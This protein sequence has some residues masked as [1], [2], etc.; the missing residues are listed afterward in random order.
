MQP[1]PGRFGEVQPGEDVRLGMC[2]TGQLEVQGKWFDST[3]LCP[4]LREVTPSRRPFGGSW[5]SSSNWREQLVVSQK[6]AGSNPVCAAPLP[7]SRRG[8]QSPTR[9]QLGSMVD[10]YDGRPSTSKT[11]FE[12][13]SSYQISLLE[14]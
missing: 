13:R 12:S 11:G 7:R 1:V 9:R 2:P 10:R 14:D 8:G 4:L 6:A 5:R 3:T